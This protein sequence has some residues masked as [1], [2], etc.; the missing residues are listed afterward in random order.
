M[1]VEARV[2]HAI[3]RSRCAPPRRLRSPKVARRQSDKSFGDCVPRLSK[4][5]ARII[6]RQ[7]FSTHF[8]ASRFARLE[9]RQRN[10]TAR[11][12]FAKFLLKCDQT[13][14]S[15]GSRNTVQVCRLK[16]VSI[17]SEI[18]GKIPRTIWTRAE[19]SE[20]TEV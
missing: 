4:K 10:R 6:A 16:Y 2:N 8:P 7:P 9:T 19:E 20:V 11:I 18:L 15:A 3:Y 17:G 1:V 14:M 5:V 13:S 12:S